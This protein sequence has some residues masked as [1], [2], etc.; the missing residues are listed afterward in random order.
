MA[1]YYRYSMSNNARIAYENGEKPMSK[2]TKKAILEEVEQ[3]VDWEDLPSAI[4]PIIKKMT[5]PQLKG[6]LNYTGWHHTSKMYNKTDFYEVDA[7][8]ILFIFYMHDIMI[9]GFKNPYED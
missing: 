6:L 8:H 9:P 7:K 4:M 1:G 3:L 5:L 2:W